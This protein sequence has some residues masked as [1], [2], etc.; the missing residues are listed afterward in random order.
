[1]TY[2]PHAIAG[3]WRTP[4]AGRQPRLALILTGT[5]RVIVW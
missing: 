5:P 4:R 1:M 2:L 3:H